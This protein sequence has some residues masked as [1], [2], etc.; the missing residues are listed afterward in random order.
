MGDG[1]RDGDRDG[2]RDGCLTLAC[3]ALGLSKYFDVCLLCLPCGGLFQKFGLQ[4]RWQFSCSL[5]IPV[6]PS[7]HLCF[8]FKSRLLPTGGN[9][10]VMLRIS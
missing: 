2:G 8:W 4:I 6:V 7:F 9:K 3:L 5:T 10:L 1:D